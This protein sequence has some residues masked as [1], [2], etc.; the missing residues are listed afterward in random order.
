MA[1]EF[2]AR[3]GKVCSVK[4]RKHT[5][6]SDAIERGELD[7]VFR[8]LAH[9]DEIPY[10][11]IPLLHQQSGVEL[12]TLR[13]WRKI[14]PGKPQWRPDPHRPK[15]YRI[16][17]EVEAAAAQRLK[18][19]VDEKKH[20]CPPR[21]VQTLLNSL[22]QEEDER[23]REL[24]ANLSKMAPSSLTM[25]DLETIDR[26][27]K[28]TR[29]QRRDERAAEREIVPI[30][31]TA[32]RNFLG[33]HG[34]GPRKYHIKRRTEPDD[35]RVEQFLTDFHTFCPHFKPQNV[36]NVDE[37]SWKV[38]NNRMVTVARIGSDEVKC[39]FDATEKD[40]ITAIAGI[41]LD[42]TKLPLWILATGTTKKTEK[43]F[44][45]NPRLQRYIRE[46]SLVVEHSESGWTTADVARKYIKWLHKRNRGDHKYLLWDVYAAHRAEEVKEY[47]IKK[48]V[49]LEFIPAGQTDEWQPLDYK[50]FGEM[51]SKAK[52]RFDSYY[53]RCLTHGETPSFGMVD[54]IITLVEVWKGIEEENVRKSWRRLTGN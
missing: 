38:L 42:G 15:H 6:Y 54:A 22:D 27:N 39:V 9:P 43:K 29:K 20:Y 18:E 31:M 30:G 48:E 53:G 50:I 45:E 11:T 24:I 51:K 4:K 49:T 14:L 16:S 5:D 13:T 2:I 28:K 17:P 41:A 23:D 37:T 44:S 47:A 40:C 3:F 34:Y 7:V 36:I 46:G 10:G 12:N 1:A 19:F 35:E 52:G 21:A 26:V 25:R 8:V 32:V 33:R